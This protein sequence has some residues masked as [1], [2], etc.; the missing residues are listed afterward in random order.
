MKTRKDYD[1]YLNRAIK[2]FKT[3]VIYFDVI[4][5]Q[6]ENY[7]RINGK[8]SLE[9]MKKELAF[10]SD[11]K[12]KD[13]D[14]KK[15]FA[16]TYSNYSKH[17]N[18]C[19]GIPSRLV[20]KVLG[21]YKDDNGTRHRISIDD[22]LK[23]C[24]SITRLRHGTKTKKDDDGKYKVCRYWIDKYMIPPKQWYIMFE[25]CP[26]DINELKNAS[27]RIKKIICEFQQ[28][29]RAKIVK[30]S[31][32]NIDENTMKSD[33]KT[34]EPQRAS[35][36]DKAQITEDNQGVMTT[37]KD[38]ETLLMAL[39]A[40]GVV[41]VSSAIAFCRSNQ[42]GINIKRLANNA[43]IAERYKGYDKTELARTIISKFN[44]SDFK[45]KMEKY[46]C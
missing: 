36:Q 31:P 35:V 42:L 6:R 12:T 16:Q 17:F 34:K 8:F 20:E 23:A 41:D 25:K 18:Y 45:R 39:V 11:W 30:S 21:E 3:L 38:D 28:S 40:S 19:F 22:V 4:R 5:P 24:S 37:R 46:Y 27:S 26:N 29:E 7:Y 9:Q 1:Y 33:V 44:D 14:F 10:L 32:K 2:D 15:R 43:S 13:D